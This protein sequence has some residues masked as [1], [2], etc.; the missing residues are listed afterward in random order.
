MDI[1]SKVNLKKDIKKN[2]NPGPPG[3]GKNKNLISFSLFNNETGKTISTFSVFKKE[4]NPA[5]KAIKS[6][7]KKFK[8]E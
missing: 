1:E 5:L 8:T 7:F 6:F 4:K 2:I 3:R